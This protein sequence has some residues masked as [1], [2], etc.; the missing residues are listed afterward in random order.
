MSITQYHYTSWP[1]HGVPAEPTDLLH[2]REAVRGTPTSGPLLVH[3]SAGVG[4]SGTFIAAD[5]ML[6][7]VQV[8]RLKPS[9]A[10]MAVKW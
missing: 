10:M 4:R 7:L 8:R 3:C 2:F 1:D 6:N 5:H 9:V